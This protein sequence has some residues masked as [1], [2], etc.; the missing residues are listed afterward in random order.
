MT[1]RAFVTGAATAL[2]AASAGA[3]P[4]A[5]GAAAGLDHGYAT[6]RDIAEAIR[7]KKISARE[8]LQET[9]QR[10]DRYNPALNAIIIEFRDRA[11]ARAREADDALAGGKPWGPLHGVPVTIK[12]AFAYAG[13]PNTWG[14]PEFKDVNSPHTAVAVARLE[15]AGAIV[16]GKTNIPAGLA[17]IQSHNAIYGTTNNPWDL[18][19]TPGGST[20]GGA[21][22]IA[23]GLGPLTLGSDFGGSIRTPAHMCGVYGHKPT[24]NLVSAA[25]HQPGPWDGRPF[26]AP[27]SNG[28]KFG[29]GRSFDFQVVGP[30]ARDARDLALALNVLGGA[31]GDEAIAWNWRMP[32][33][34]QKRL[35]DFRIGYVTGRRSVRD[36]LSAP[37]AATLPLN[38]PVA[39]D[40]LE[41]Y[42]NVLSA[43]A[44]A[45]ARLEQGWPDGID[46]KSQSETH[47]Y[48]GL[49]RLSRSEEQLA[50]DRQRLQQDPNNRTALAFAGPHSRWSLETERQLDSA[51]P[52][53]RTSGRMTSSCYRRPPPPH[54]LMTTASSSFERRIETPD[55]RFTSGD[56][57]YWSVFATVPG[58]P[59]TVAP[60][61]RTRSG[62]PTGIQIIAPMWE[63][64]TSI[65]F[66]ALLSDLVGVVHSPAWI[67]IVIA[68]GRATVESS[69]GQ[70]RRAYRRGPAGAR[71]EGR[72]DEAERWLCAAIDAARDDGAGLNWIEALG[73]LAHVMRDLGGLTPRCRCPRKRCASAAPWVIGCSWRTRSGTS[74]ICIATRSVL[75]R[76][77]AATTRRW[78]SIATPA[79]CDAPDFA[80][81]L[82]PT[83]MLKASQGQWREARELF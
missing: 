79:I 74:A 57:G 72:L 59:A 60:A 23:A 75:T 68:V 61:G 45:G 40:V 47:T 22:A 7:R 51:P 21:A 58:L 63:D 42:E 39:S 43:L 65:E 26:R 82:R 25:G 32:P 66:A 69:D 28:W 46:F 4:D 67:L 78:R 55:G 44:R 19:R 71:R 81:A 31:A 54:F 56:F 83:A 16:I 2:L 10:I 29:Q 35:R 3:S 11:L 17:D 37:G 6:A 27:D 62:L 73:K 9:F 38:E 50:R 48:L 30:L 15:S 18:S 80:N 52:G 8:M 70:R 34:R 49:S 53:R 13:S 12:E 24:V 33:P 77:I 41:V 14:M 64:G 5:T 76:R 1:R 20:G 36:D